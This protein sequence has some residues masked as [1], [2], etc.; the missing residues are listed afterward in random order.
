MAMVEACLFSRF[1][2]LLRDFIFADMPG[3]TEKVLRPDP[4]QHSGRKFCRGNTILCWQR[5]YA[6]RLPKASSLLPMAWS[7]MHLS[8]S[9][10]RHDSSTGT[11][12]SRPINKTTAHRPRALPSAAEAHISNVQSVSCTL[13]ETQYQNSCVALSA[14]H[15]TNP[16][17]DLVHGTAVIKTTSLKKGRMYPVDVE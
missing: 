5:V 16:I 9:I 13:I 6:L 11:I 17:R 7:T 15:P 4:C 3:V 10:I 1:R 2:N 12:V 8:I 14:Q